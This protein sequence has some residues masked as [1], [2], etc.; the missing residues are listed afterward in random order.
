MKTEQHTNRPQKS[1]KSERERVKSI[2]HHQRVACVVS[3]S[4][5]TKAT[6]PMERDTQHILE[7]AR[8]CSVPLAIKLAEGS[9][10]ADNRV[11]APA[12]AT[13]QKTSRAN[14]ISQLSTFGPPSTPSE[15][16]DKSQ[17]RTED[18][19]CFTP[20]IRSTFYDERGG[21]G[22]GT[23]SPALPQRT[24][25]SSSSDC[26]ILRESRFQDMQLLSSPLHGTITETHSAAEEASKQRAISSLRLKKHQ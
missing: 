20:I 23:P 12:A 16:D 9:E 25:S 19:F 26:S 4:I 11:A 21:G 18:Y 3:S 13:W 14:E 6:L 10:P 22:M 24:Y 1:T 5:T 17:K 7:H 15:R 2:S 8:V